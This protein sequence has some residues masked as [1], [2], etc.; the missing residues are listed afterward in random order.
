MA[1]ATKTGQ[2]PSAQLQQLLAGLTA[3]R[4]GDFSARLPE[5]SDP[6]M[7]EIADGPAR[8]AHQPR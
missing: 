5:G 7:N 4:S 2:P 8:T 6:L 3:V 1:T